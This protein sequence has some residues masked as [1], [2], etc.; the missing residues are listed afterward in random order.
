[1]RKLLIAA[2]LIAALPVTALAVVGTPPGTGPALQDG[3]WLNGLAGGQN[4]AYQAGLVAT[5][6]T[7]ATCTAI[8][9]GY[10]L[11]EVDTATASTG[12]GVCLPFALPGTRLLVYN[13]S[14]QTITFYPA[15]L[16]NP[17]S[18]AQDTINNGTSKTAATH[19]STMF[20]SVAAGVWAAQ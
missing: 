19:V 5:G 13:N 18:A 10:E 8:K 7:Q 9:P 1:M 2:A 16:N 6:T 3:I 17:V 4:W 11:N 14:G 15:I 12:L 20:Y